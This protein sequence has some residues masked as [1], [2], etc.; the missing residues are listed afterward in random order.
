MAGLILLGRCEYKVLNVWPSEELLEYCVSPL[1]LFPLL[2]L[3]HI[4]ILSL[5]LKLWQ[6][7]QVANPTSTFSP[8]STFLE[9]V[10]NNFVDRVFRGYH[11]LSIPPLAI[12]PILCKF[13]P[14]HITDSYKG[15]N[16]AQDLV[17][18]PPG[19]ATHMDSGLSITPATAGMQNCLQDIVAGLGIDSW[20]T[21]GGASELLFLSSEGCEVDL[22][23]CGC[24][25]HNIQA[26]MWF[27]VKEAWWESCNA[28]WGWFFRH[29]QASCI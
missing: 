22:N 13:Q 14:Q 19:E 21:E 17:C 6:V 5:C 28:H 12:C 18:G 15:N 26:V 9:R 3:K 20:W 23:E 10:S 2:R 8:L 7:C 24:F 4:H 27:Q 29:L 25:S 11:H 1:Y 16:L